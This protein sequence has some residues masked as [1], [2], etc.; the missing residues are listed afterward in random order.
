LKASGKIRFYPAINI[1]EPVRHHPAVML[2]FLVDRQHILVLKALDDH[3][4]HGGL[5]KGGIE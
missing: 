4:K 2:E 1:F 5:P 3:E